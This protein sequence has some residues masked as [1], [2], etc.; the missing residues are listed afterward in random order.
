MHSRFLF[1]TEWLE[2]HGHKALT[3]GSPHT[4]KIPFMGFYGLLAVTK[5]SMERF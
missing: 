3:G 2:W 4:N 5:A 1:Y